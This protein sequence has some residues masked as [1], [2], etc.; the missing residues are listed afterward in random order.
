M[1]NLVFSFQMI[2]WRTRSVTPQYEKICSNFFPS[3]FYLS[4]SIFF[5]NLARMPPK[6]PHWAY[7]EDSIANAISDI[8]NNGISQYQAA[9]KWG[10]PRT[11]LSGRLRGQTAMADQIQPEKRLSNNQE[12]NLVA[13]ILRQESLGYAPSHSQIRAC[14]L[15]LLKQQ[16]PKSSFGRNWVSRFIKRHPELKTKIGRRQEASRFNSFTPKAVHWYFDIRE[17]EYGWIRPEN[18][19]N[20][21]E[22]GIM[23]GFGKLIST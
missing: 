23:A 7:S 10:V 6:K 13:W 22:G 4:L 16:D 21:D 5:S 14:A 8:E 18:T 20:I 15:A 17:K 2:L 9:Q 19:V 12:S 11:T 3:L 1:I